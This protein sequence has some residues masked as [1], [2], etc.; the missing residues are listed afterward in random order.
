MLGVVVLNF[1]VFGRV[2]ALEGGCVV[3]WRCLSRLTWE[4]CVVGDVG[5]AD[6]NLWMVWMSLRWW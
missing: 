6:L 1:V 3:G 4:R 5:A 2:G